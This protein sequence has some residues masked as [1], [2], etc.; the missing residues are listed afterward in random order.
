MFSNLIREFNHVYFVRISDS[1][2]QELEKAKLIA[3]PNP[4]V[5]TTPISI[6]EIDIL[7][8]VLLY[9]MVVVLLV[10]SSLA[11][12]TTSATLLHH[13]LKIKMI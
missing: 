7:V 6:Q 1:M 8:V 10:A 13:R 3:P 11:E 2:Q 9:D 5:N 4:L 12:G